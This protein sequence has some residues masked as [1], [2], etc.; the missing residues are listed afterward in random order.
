MGIQIIK[1]MLYKLIGGKLRGLDKQVIITTTRR[2][3]YVAIVKVM[4]SLNVNILFGDPQLLSFDQIV[5]I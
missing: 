1:H 3:L 5:T 2:A 4:L